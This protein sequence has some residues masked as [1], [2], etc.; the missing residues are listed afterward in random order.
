[1][2]VSHLAW[3]AKGVEHLE[4]R[5]GGCLATQ[6]LPRLL[7]GVTIDFFIVPTINFKVLYV[8]VVLAHHRREVIYFQCHGAPDGPVGRA[9]DD[10]GLSMGYCI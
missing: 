1:V 4:A 10:R 2:G 6:A 7:G 5:Y 9:T 8:L 3:L